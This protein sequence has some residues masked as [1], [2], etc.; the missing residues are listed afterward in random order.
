MKPSAHRGRLEQLRR[1]LEAAIAEPTPANMAAVADAYQA[2]EFSTDEDDDA[3]A[4]AR[5]NDAIEMYAIG[6]LGKRL[7]ARLGPSAPAWLRAYVLGEDHDGPPANAIVYEC[8]IC[9]AEVES[10]PGLRAKCSD[11]HPPAQ[12]VAREPRE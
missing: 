2:V 7:I 10:A 1:A 4:A 3:D 11:G 8:P 12:L 9:G 5:R 6:P